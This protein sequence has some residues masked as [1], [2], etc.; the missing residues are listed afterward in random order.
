MG[1]LAGKFQDAHIGSSIPCGRIDSMLVLSGHAN[2]LL[3]SVASREDPVRVNM[4]PTEKD[5]VYC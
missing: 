5:F 3:N 4:E 1:S 2:V